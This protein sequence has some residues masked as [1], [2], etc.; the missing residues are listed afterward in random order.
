MDSTIF[1][2]M[3]AKK[4]HCNVLSRS[5]SNHVLVAEFRL[6]TDS[7]HSVSLRALLHARYIAFAQSHA[8]IVL[9]ALQLLSKI[10]VDLTLLVL[11]VSS[12]S[13]R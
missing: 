6:L 11:K 8:Y 4:S 13:I 12:K 1:L 9:E 7:F 2:L 10:V 5:F 3:A